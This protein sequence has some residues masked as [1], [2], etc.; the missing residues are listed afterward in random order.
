MRAEADARRSACRES[1]AAEQLAAELDELP[2]RR[3]P[4]KLHAVIIVLVVQEHPIR[5]CLV[6]EIP[7]VGMLLVEIAD[8]REEAA[9]TERHAP[10]QAGCLDERLLDR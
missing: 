5:Q 4:A 8:A 7:G 3:Q 6:G 10:W 2:G 9:G 1:I